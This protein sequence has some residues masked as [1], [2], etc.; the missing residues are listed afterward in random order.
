MRKIFT[1]MLLLAWMPL[2]VWGQDEITGYWTDENVREEVTSENGVYKIETPGQLGWI[3]WKINEG[4]GLG[5][6]YE[7]ALLNDIDLS[8]HYWVPISGFYRN[9][10]GNNHTIRNIAISAEVVDGF[11][12]VGFFQKITC[13]NDY[14]V[15]DLTLE[16]VTVNPKKFGISRLGAFVASLGG[17]V[18]NCHVKNATIHVAY[19]NTTDVGGFAGNFQN[20]RVDNC[21][22]GDITILIEKPTTS[23]SSF[24]SVR[25]GGFAGYLSMN[26]ISSIGM[27]RNCSVSGTIKGEKTWTPGLDNSFFG[28]L[29]GKVESTSANSATSTIENCHSSFNIELNTIPMQLGLYDKQIAGGL[30]GSIEGRGEPFIELFNCVYS[31]KIT[32]ESDGKSQIG[33]LI[34]YVGQTTPTAENCFYPSGKTPVGDETQS[35][36]GMQEISDNTKEELN[37]W[38]TENSTEGNEY[39]TWNTDGNGNLVFTE[40]ETSQPVE[41]TDYKWEGN[42]CTLLTPEGLLWFADQVNNQHNTFIGKTVT[43]A[44][45]DWDMTSEDWVPIGNKE[46]QTSALTP[47]SGTFD[48]NNQTV[49]IKGSKGGFF[50][51]VKDGT[52]QNLTVDGILTEVDDD[53]VGMLIGSM[54]NGTVS[55]VTTKGSIK[56]ETEGTLYIGGVIGEAD[57]CVITNGVSEVDI[58]SDRSFTAHGGIVG[59]GVDSQISDCINKGDVTS[60][61]PWVGGIVGY[62]IGNGNDS[63][64]SGCINEGKINAT[65]TGQLSYWIGGIVGM[66]EIGN[67]GAKAVVSDCVNNG[68]VTEGSSS[69]GKYAVGG[70]VGTMESRK[71]VDSGEVTI[72]NSSNNGAIEGNAGNAYVGGIVGI[73]EGG[74]TFFSEDNKKINSAIINCLNTGPVTG[75]SHVSGIGTVQA[76]EDMKTQ[77]ECCINQGVVTGSGTPTAIFAV[78]SKTDGT[79][80]IKNS[81]YQAQ[82][83]LEATLGDQD[84]GNLIIENLQEIPGGEEWLADLNEAI[85]AYNTEYPNGPMALYWVFDK[86]GKLT[87][88]I[89]APTIEGDTPFEESTE[90]AINVLAGTTVYYTTDGSDPAT[91]STSYSDPITITETTTIKAIAVMDEYESP[92]S[93]MVFKK[94]PAVPVISTEST[95]FDESIT[96]EITAEE[97][98]EIY[99]T[100][101]GSDPTTSSELYTG[102]LIFTETTTLKAIAVVDGIPS[103]VITVVLTKNEPEPEDP[104]IPDYPDYYNIYV[105]ECEGV[106]IETSTNVV[107][108]GNSMTFTIEVADG[109]TAENMVVKLKRSLFGYTEIIK[110][111]KEGVYEVKN[112][113]TEIYITVEGV[114]LKEVPTGMEEITGIKVYVQEGS[115]YVQTPKLEQ[116]T[117]ISIT[118]AIVENETQLGLKRYDLPRG[119]YI[120]CVGEE[121][122]KIRN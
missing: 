75:N 77:I 28:G 62:L 30:C 92:I 90:I 21:S 91:T 38:V 103:E 11:T 98:A 26:S 76:Q 109:Y 60:T 22:V 71:D 41:G 113:Y 9:F 42:V 88:G 13:S 37:Q 85:S 50:G 54:E 114:E 39:R 58:T 40:E 97:D 48:G 99:Y 80:T 56:N 101:D 57:E 44:T 112:I 27:I 25:A 100:T 107:R 121:Q 115:I 84:S 20:A 87:F 111:D 52:V 49:K 79:I 104:V 70:I 19:N 8:G 63:Q 3:A 32:Q 23:G 65:R 33:Y 119:I 93:E 61:V 122:K 96:V 34:G 46:W 118:G 106:T 117:I 86:D 15:S 24:Y 36:E 108:E 29:I 4:G 74:Q 53:Y 73:A 72:I 17:N 116:V 16:E 6:N 66:I 5:S 1:L 10:K 43:L 64:I 14:Y 89:P 83:G 2:A 94:A 18:K 31:G 78:Y 12:W 68:S 120:I 110:P 51:C 7:V 82:S 45:R 35:S 67:N 59:Y 55:N 102:A 81:Y 47:F 105:D 95:T 69:N